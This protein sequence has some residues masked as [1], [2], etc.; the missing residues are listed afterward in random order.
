M[1]SPEVGIAMLDQR[2]VRVRS[3]KCVLRGAVA[4]P[5]AD[6]RRVIHDK[7]QQYLV[8]HWTTF[9]FIET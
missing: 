7:M 1:E 5:V 3:E 6:P 4:T 2:S 9:F 8:Y